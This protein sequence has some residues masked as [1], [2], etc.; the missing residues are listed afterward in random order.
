MKLEIDSYVKN[1]MIFYYV[2]M[3]TKEGKFNSDSNIIYSLGI[4]EKKYNKLIRT[5]NGIKKCSSDFLNLKDIENF[6]DQLESIIVLNKLM[7]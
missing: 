2:S 3:S 7:E 5:N 6:I 1:N 4:K